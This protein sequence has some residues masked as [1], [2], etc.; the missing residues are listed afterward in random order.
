MGIYI[1]KTDVNTFIVRF[2]EFITKKEL[3]Y[4]TKIYGRPVFCKDD[5]SDNNETLKNYYNTYSC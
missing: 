3:E 5:I 1:W 2:K 4:F